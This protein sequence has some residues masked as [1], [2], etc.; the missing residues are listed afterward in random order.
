M[1]TRAH[2]R[3]ERE[4]SSFACGDGRLRP[5]QEEIRR[6]PGCGDGLARASVSQ[7]RVRRVDSPQ[8]GPAW[9]DHVRAARAGL[10]RP[11]RNSRR[12]GAALHAFALFSTGVPPRAVRRRAANSPVDAPPT[13]PSTH[14]APACDCRL[15]QLAASAWKH[16]RRRSS[17]RRWILHTRDSL[18]PS[19]SPISRNGRSSQ[20]LR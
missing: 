13:P 5:W 17:N 14:A 10:H 3:K 12:H 8:W 6:G 11:G 4:R 19:S 20:Y 18:R 2:S 16:W 7:R 1:G 15:R 9:F